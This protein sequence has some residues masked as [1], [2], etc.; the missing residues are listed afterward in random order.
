MKKSDTDDRKE[1]EGL[2][3][4]GRHTL[5]VETTVIAYVFLALFLAL[6]AYFVYFEAFKSED[7]INNAANPRIKG[8]EKL[9]VRGQI[10]ASDGTVLA[11]TVEKNGTEVR[12]YPKGREY[13]HV[14]GFNTNGMSGLE[15]DK[16]F[17]ML[18]SHAFILTRVINDLKGL[19]NPGDNVVT[20]LDTKLTDTAYNGMGYYNGAVVALD[21]NTGGVLTMVSKPDFDPNTVSSN[22]K[23]L[24]SDSGSSLLNRAIQGLYPPGSTFKVVTA[25]SYLKN[26]GKLSDTF[27][28]KGEYTKGGYTI[29]CYGGEVHGKQN[30]KQA[31]ANSCNVSFS[32]VGLFLPKGALKSTAEE[33]GFN[34]SLGADFSNVKKSRFTLRSSDGDALVMQTAIGQGNTL[35]TPL[36]MA[37]ICEAVANDGVITEPFVADHIEN[38]TGSLVRSHSKKTKRLLS[39][40]EADTLSSLMRYVVTNGTGRA[41]NTDLYKAYG[42]TGTAEFSSNKDEAHSWFIGFAQKG[43]KKIAVAVIMEKAGAGSSH[44]APLAKKMFDEYFQE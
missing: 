13:A 10:K 20:S 38:D 6:A 5:N 22:W 3:G 29:H 2:I 12:N 43:E 7:F 8:F 31:F 41:L 36:H 42:K 27:D 37:L 23:A 24:T 26:G 19:K 16:S 18:R 15:A 30:L 33:F 44:A 4:K 11:E 25:L 17:Y 40:E 14:V 35:V 21:C 39:E 1:R 32:Q 34:R 28:C 9:V